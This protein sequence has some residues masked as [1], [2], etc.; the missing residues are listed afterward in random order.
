MSDAPLTRARFL[1]ALSDV[2]EG[3]A[4]A[5]DSTARLRRALL[6]FASETPDNLNCAALIEVGAVGSEIGLKLRERD[7]P[8]S[9]IAHAI[10]DA[11]MP[12]T[13]A[14]AFPALTEDDWSAFSRLTTLIYTLLTRDMSSNR[15]D[16]S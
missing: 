12:E 13:V 4:G 10:E 8:F 6:D 2:A 5:E 11:P 14:A 7:L 9:E 3:D 15:H 1:R 16:P